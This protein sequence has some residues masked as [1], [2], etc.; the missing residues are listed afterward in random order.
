M[1]TTRTAQG[2][3]K[4]TYNNETFEVSYSQELNE[5]KVYQDGEWCETLPTLNAAKAWIVS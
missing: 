5:W 3:Y 1:K 2:E 4:I